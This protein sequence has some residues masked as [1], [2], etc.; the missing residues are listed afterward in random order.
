MQPARAHESLVP[1]INYYDVCPL[2]VSG[3]L[4]RRHTGGKS[5]KYHDRCIA[6]DKRHRALMRQLAFTIEKRKAEDRA[7]EEKLRQR[8]ASEH[9]RSENNVV[10]DN[11]SNASDTVVSSRRKGRPRQKDKNSAK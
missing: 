8:Y 1:A 3:Q 10:D 7:K 5:H 9:E 4:L 11:G 6:Y 2:F